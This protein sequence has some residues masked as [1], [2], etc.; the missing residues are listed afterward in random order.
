MPARMVARII[1]DRTGVSGAKR[2]GMALQGGS[3]VFCERREGSLEELW[4]GNHDQVE[5]NRRLVFSEDL[6]NQSFSA[7]PRHRPAESSGCADAKAG[8]PGPVRQRDERHEAPVRPGTPLLNPEVIGPAPDAFW[9][10]EALGHLP[11][12]PF[13]AP[14]WP[15][16][17]TLRRKG[18]LRRNAQALPPLRA[19]AIEHLSPLLRLH[20]NQEAV[21][22]FSTPP[23][24][25]KRAFHAMEPRSER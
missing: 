25:L 16:C 20:A 23:I 10:P 6:S 3:E 2:A 11:A 8:L 13:T 15:D 9:R 17:A 4:P 18:L 1:R 19:A 12:G 21:R 22:A 5:T 7:V 24:G 14:T